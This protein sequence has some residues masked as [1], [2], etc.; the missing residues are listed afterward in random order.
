[1]KNNYY[2]EEDDN[3][4]NFEMS[5]S[6]NQKN[7]NYKNENNKAENQ[8]KNKDYVVNNNSFTQSDIDEFKNIFNQN[9]FK[10]NDAI[11]NK[12]YDSSNLFEGSEDINKKDDITLKDLDPKIKEV[13]ILF[14]LSNDYYQLLVQERAKKAFRFNK[15]KKKKPYE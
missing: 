6:G 13:L 7:L 12:S 8:I 3:S 4:N 5:P 1:M 9:D 11:N 15:V 2:D 14:V 10:N